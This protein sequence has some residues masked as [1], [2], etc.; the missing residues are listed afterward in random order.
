MKDVLGKDLQNFIRKI[1]P[2]EDQLKEE[3]RAYAKENHV[4]IVDPEVAN[5]L[6]VITAIKKPEKILEIGTGL[7]YSTISMAKS[8][9]GTGRIT[10]L[11]ILP[12]RK[13]KAE[14]FI[15]KAGYSDKIKVI[16]ADGR[17]IID[18]FE[19][20]FDMVFL[21][22]AKGQ[23]PKFFEKFD[24]LIKEDGIIVADNVL[25]NGWVIN[26]DYPDRRKKT[27]VVKMKEFLEKFKENKDYEMTL[28]PLGDGLAI[29]KKKVVNK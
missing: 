15:K 1:L 16:C 10:T 17:Q 26:L 23:Y 13:E 3:I 5:F 20:R 8:L 25:I 6:R 7:A 29:I 9:P 27:M 12:N 14:Y 19:E 11:E 21:D 24:K 22:A 18:Q 28:I 4:S 2:A